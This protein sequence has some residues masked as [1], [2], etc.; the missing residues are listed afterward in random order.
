VGPAGRRAA[1]QPGAAPPCRAPCT[2]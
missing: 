2:Q 1:H